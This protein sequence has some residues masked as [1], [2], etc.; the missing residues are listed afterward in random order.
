MN[1]ME[2]P[3]NSLRQPVLLQT[4]GVINPQTASAA[5]QTVALER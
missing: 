4:D 1:S 2:G 3:V 5:A